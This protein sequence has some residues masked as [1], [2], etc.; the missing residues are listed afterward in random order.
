MI[1]RI[2]SKSATQGELKEKYEQ[3]KLR[4]SKFFIREY[5]YKRLY[6]DDKLGKELE[7]IANKMYHMRAGKFKS[8]CFEALNEEQRK[9]KDEFE[10]PQNLKRVLSYGDKKG[11]E[12]F[13]F[14]KDKKPE[15]FK[16]LNKD[17]YKI[18][19]LNDAINNNRFKLDGLKHLNATLL[20]E[21]FNYSPDQKNLI[22]LSNWERGKFVSRV[23]NEMKKNE[24]FYCHCSVG[25]LLL[26]YTLVEP[27]SGRGLSWEIDRK[28]P[29]K[30]YEPANCAIAC[31]Y[32]NNA[33]SDVFDDEQFR[34]VGEMIGKKIREAIEPFLAG[35]IL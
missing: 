10:L 8:P 31:Y 6:C 14:C 7:A 1:E 12:F 18:E 23:T 29:D 13:E 19:N 20:C 11:V 22:S 30:N 28:K 26:F 33:K 5:L 9:V 35:N 21:I 15:L 27:K 4:D 16:N 2:L 3:S 32:C 34:D 17:Y 24:C 25:Q